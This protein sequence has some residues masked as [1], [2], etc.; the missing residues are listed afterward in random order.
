MSVDYFLFLKN[1]YESINKYQQ[2]IFNTY[3]AIVEVS[4][5]ENKQNSSLHIEDIKELSGY[6]NEYGEKIRQTN[7]FI[8]CI[9]QKLKESCVHSFVKDLIDI[10]PD[11]SKEIE[12][13][14]I[15]E[16]DRETY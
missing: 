5:N 10:T 3:T 2:E 9:Q 12:Y 1:K 13:C 7:Y 8:K 15:C 6:K 16:C 4:I 14:E 11:K